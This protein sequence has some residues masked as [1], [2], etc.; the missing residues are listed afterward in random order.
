MSRNSLKFWYTI[1]KG[2]AKTEKGKTYKE[3]LKGNRCMDSRRPELFSA[4]SG[5]G[6]SGCAAWMA[7]RSSL[8]TPQRYTLRIKRDVNTSFDSRID[9]PSKVLAL[10]NPLRQDF[11]QH[12]HQHNIM[13]TGVSVVKYLI[14]LYNT[15]AH[16]YLMSFVDC[17]ILRDCESCSFRPCRATL[18]GQR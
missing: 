3:F 8:A 13:N 14:T 12:Y 7:V 16:V 6:A 4:G 18:F 15:S 1:V 10:R 9:K 11:E 2:I 17:N 5:F